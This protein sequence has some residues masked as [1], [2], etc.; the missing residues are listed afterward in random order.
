MTNH[1]DIEL[2]I[3][4][5]GNKCIVD[6]TGD[7]DDHDGTLN[8][9]VALGAIKEALRL[10]LERNDQRNA[11]QVQYDAACECIRILE[12]RLHNTEQ[13]LHATRGKALEFIART[14]TPRVVDIASGT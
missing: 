10:G 4:E 9:K 12:S 1:W 3:I 2:T 13:Q 8:V 7:P 14:N 5:M 6:I 11:L